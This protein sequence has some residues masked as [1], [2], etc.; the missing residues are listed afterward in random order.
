MRPLIMERE[1]KTDAQ[2]EKRAANTL[3]K[4]TSVL[5]KQQQNKWISCD[6]NSSVLE[7]WC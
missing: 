1:K 7:L 2:D 3:S 6:L 4:P 5:K